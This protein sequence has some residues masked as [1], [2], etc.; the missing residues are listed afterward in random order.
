M[1][2]QQAASRSSTDRLAQ[3]ESALDRLVTSVEREHPQRAE[4]VRAALDRL[5]ERLRHLHQHP[6]EVNES[7]WAQYITELE[8]GLDELQIE[9]ARAAEPADS[10]PTLEDLLNKRTTALELSGWRLRVDAA[11]ARPESLEPDASMPAAEHV[12]AAS[13]ALGDYERLPY[14]VASVARANLERAMAALRG[15]VD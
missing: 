14:P 3:V 10:G 6:G 4:P 11:R 15:A 12:E 1:A 7:A 2:E 13:R 5:R 9:I 8:R